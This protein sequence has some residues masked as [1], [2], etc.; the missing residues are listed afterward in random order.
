ML[1]RALLVLAML[2]PAAAAGQT[3]SGDPAAA[4]VEQLEEAAA[5]GSVDAV[6]ALGVTAESSGVRMFAALAVPKPTRFIIKER[7][8]TEREPEGETL[9]LEVFGEYGSQ[10]TITTWRAEVVPVEGDGTTRRIATI[11]ELTTISGLYKLALNTAKQFHVRNLTVQATDLKLEI[12]SGSAFVAETPEGPTAIVLLGRGKMMFSPSDAAE[13]TQIRIFSG[14]NALATDFDAVFI[15]VRPGEA[16][17]VL[18]PAALKPVP[19]AQGDLRRATDLF[20]DYIGQT[21]SLDLR[22]LSRDRWSLL[23]AI[24]DLL[25]EVRTRRLGSLTYARS[26]KDAEDISLFERRRRRNIAVYASPQ[27][28]ATRGRFYGEDE[29]VEYDI[30]RQ[31]VEVAFSPDRMWV[32]GTATLEVRVRAFALATLT[33]RLADPLVVRNVVARDFGRL[34]HLRVVGQNSVLV[35]LPSTVQRNGIIRLTVV[36]GGRLEPQQ[37]EREGLVLDQPSNQQQ[38]EIYIP[39]EP[40]YI[41]SNRSYWYPQNTVTDY[42]ISRLRITVPSEFDVVASG[43]ETAPPSPAPGQGSRKL[44]V[45]EATQPLR[46]LA[47]AISRFTRVTTREMLIG[48][49]NDPLAAKSVTLNVQ[50]NPRQTSRARGLADRAASIYEYYGRLIGDA[51]Y[52]SFTLAVAENDLPGGHSPGYF[53]ILNQP[54]PLSPIVW[55]NDPVAFESYQPYFLAHEIAHQWWGQAIGWKNYHEQWISEGFA[56]Y[57]AALYAERDRGDDVFRGMLRQMRRWSMEQSEQGPVYLGYRLGHIKSEGRVFRAI[58]YNKGAMVLHMLRRLVGDEKFFEGIRQFYATWRFRKAGTDDFRL[59]MQK[60]S[61]TD[62][63]AFFDSWIYGANVPVLGFSST[64]NGGEARLRF[65]HRGVVMPTPVTVSIAYTDGTS[66]DV[67]VPVTERVAE[68]TIELRGAV[69]T[70]EANRDYGAVAEI[71]K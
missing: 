41:Y 47:C 8:R 44:F 43:V 45:F 70:I 12:P 16:D 14:E 66:E 5:A 1:L 38:E 4:L 9:L 3:R 18:P 22:D 57:F 2:W 51:P 65:E 19:V 60:A 23:P 36:Y 33:L 62:L 49:E 25:A 69:R 11:E 10:A 21:F 15:R 64:V 53:A 26:T 46:Y 34:L 52:P 28:L 6:M 50:A 54:P 7:D 32:E 40:Q 67:I 39:I 27:K 58:V 68:R 29:L 24:G 31:D 61:G 56:Q 63:T 17:D 35:N 59:A 30:L 48:P 13:R 42:A 20:D 71:E 37:I 55:R